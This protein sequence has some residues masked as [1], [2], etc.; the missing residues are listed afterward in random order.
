MTSVALQANGQRRIQVRPRPA[1]ATP[2]PVRLCEA[3]S[4]ALFE[5]ESGRRPYRQIQPLL[6]Y[7]LE[8]RVRRRLHR[9]GSLGAA[10][11]L[12]A[13]PSAPAEVLSVRADEP[14]PGVVEAVVVIRSGD[15]VEAV[16]VRCE[17]HRGRWVVMDLSRPDD[18]PT[19]R[20]SAATP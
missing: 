7:A 11:S 2:D 1:P 13:R 5:V 12:V 19:R 17:Q 9:R 6:S 16:A 20:A 14:A 18:P 10:A 3:I 4:V 8:E 15:R